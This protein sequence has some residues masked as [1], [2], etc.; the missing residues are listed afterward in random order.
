MHPATDGPSDATPTDDQVRDAIAVL[1]QERQPPATMCPSEA[2]RMLAPENW[3]VLMPQVRAVAVAMAND[4]LLDIRQGGRTLARDAPCAGPS[5]SV[6]PSGTPRDTTPRRTAATS[7][8]AD[9]SGARPTRTCP[10]TCGKR[11]SGS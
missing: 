5:A 6:G 7:S 1:L 3:K 11:S 10:R 4:G 2:A 9:G 8:C